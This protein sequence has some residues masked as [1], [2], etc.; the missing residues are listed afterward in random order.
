MCLKPLTVLHQ[1]L[2]PDMCSYLWLLHR[3]QSKKEDRVSENTRKTKVLLVFF[4]ISMVQ[5]SVFFRPGHVPI[6]TPPCVRSPDP[7]THPLTLAHRTKQQLRP[8]SEQKGCVKARG[9]EDGLSK[10]LLPVSDASCSLVTGQKYKFCL[11]VQSL[12]PITPW[13]FFLRGRRGTQGLDWVYMYS[14]EVS[15]PLGQC[16]DMSVRWQVLIRDSVRGEVQGPG[17]N[18]SQSFL[19]TLTTVATVFSFCFI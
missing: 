19:S 8:I 15:F 16:E 13:P 1:H 9:G 2:S 18:D 3:H 4:S 10:E 14:W 12:C 6:Q 17:Y 7:T 11:R 5:Q